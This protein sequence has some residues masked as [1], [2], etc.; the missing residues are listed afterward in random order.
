MKTTERLRVKNASKDCPRK[1]PLE[2]AL[3]LAELVLCGELPTVAS[4]GSQDFRGKGPGIQG[5][6][7]REDPTLDLDDP[8]PSKVAQDS[9][10][11]GESRSGAKA[12]RMCVHLSHETSI[13][14]Q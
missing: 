4:L 8:Q 14:Q 7:R 6:G 3:F 2:K 10:F 11:G 1:S 12:G 9:A 5:S 13:D